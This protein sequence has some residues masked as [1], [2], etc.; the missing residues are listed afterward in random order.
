[1]SEIIVIEEQKDKTQ[2]DFN[3]IDIKIEDNALNNLMVF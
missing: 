2:P 1:M 3:Y